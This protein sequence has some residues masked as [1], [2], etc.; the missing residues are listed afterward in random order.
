M[1]KAKYF[2]WFCS[3]ASFGILKR[4]PTESSKFTGIGAT[5]LFTGLFA[6]LAGAYASY[7]IFNNYWAALGFSLLWGGMIFNLDRYIVSSMFT[8]RKTNPWIVAL[9]RIV[10]AVLIALV[11]SKPLELKIFEKEINEE[12]SLMKEELREEKILIIRNRYTNDIQTLNSE[13]KELSNVVSEKENQRN[14]LMSIAQQ[15]ADGTGG[16]MKR[17]VGPIY[18]IK[19][20]DLDLTE[21]ELI[22]LKQRLLPLIDKKQLQ[23]FALRNDR[24]KTIEN[25]GIIQFDGMAAQLQA[26]GNLSNKNSKINLANWFIIFL[27]IAIETAP[28]FVKLLAPK[29]PYDDMLDI[30]ETGF[31]FYREEKITLMKSG[32]EQ[33]IKF[34]EG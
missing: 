18:R 28:V 30:H 1:K 10:L 26:L 9:P 14:E 24:D 16:T 8:S 3:G 31:S 33:R 29:G 21:N 13:I 12:L 17:N 5:I 19:K 34:Q 2:F 23:I 6:A 7:T 25:L 32:M 27:F 20:T 11:I 15:E 4:C 22:A